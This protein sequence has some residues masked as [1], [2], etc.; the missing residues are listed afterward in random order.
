MIS[1][2]EKIAYYSKDVSLSYSD[3]YLLPTFSDIRS[4]FGPQIDLSTSIALGASKLKTPFISAGMDTV[5]EDDMAIVFALNGGMGEIHRNNAP[6]V[7]ADMVRRVKEK[8]RTMEKHPPMVPEEATLAQA[9]E[10]LTKR[11]RGYVMVYKGS[12]YKGY[13]SGM[14][15]DKDFLAADK[16]AKITEVMTPFSAEQGKSLMTVKKGTT[17]TEAVAVMK[18]ERIEKVPVID[19]DNKL[20]G[21]YTL[22]DHEYL[23]RYPNAATDGYGRLMVGAAI[24]VHSIDVERVVR[25]VEVGVDVL[26]LDIAHGHSIYSQEMIKRLKIKEKIK[27]PIIV[28]NFATSEGVKF[29]CDVGA[30]AVKVGIGPGYVCKTRNVAG[31]GVP[32]ITAILE[33]RE[34]M[35]KRREKPPI[36]ADGGI[37]EPGDIGKAI[38]CG[39][40]SVM[41]GSIFA[42]TDKSP[43]DMVRINGVLQKRIR[44]MASRGVLEDRKKLGEST[45]NIKV[46]APE[47]REIFTP[48]QGS[49]QELLHEYIGGLRSAMSYAGA[50]TI[51]QMQKSRLIHIS[52]SGSGEQVRPLS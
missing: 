48:Y 46:Y 20:V 47:G 34:T 28:G 31:T 19:K 10:L 11:N 3:V 7:Q 24:G 32:Q 33:A 21:V 12:N 2:R 50:H 22:K 37:R 1:K 14:A 17:L 30:D 41:I 52:S 23:Q 42:G 49:T 27:T 8:M 51:A 13:V 9:L 6:E 45:T 39:A 18:K 5:T 15:T 40:D 43:G 36:I 29:A 44:G 35:E 16:D 38:A 4:R 25:L 26:F